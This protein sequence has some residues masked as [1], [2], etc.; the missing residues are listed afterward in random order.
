MLVKPANIGV[1]RAVF[2]EPLTS[3][4]VLVSWLFLLASPELLRI[5]SA[6]NGQWPPDKVLGIAII[7]EHLCA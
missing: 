7:Q 6:A 2:R 4:F 5:R 3:P 1:A